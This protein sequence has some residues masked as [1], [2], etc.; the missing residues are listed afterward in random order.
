MA[1]FAAK[2]VSE[3]ARPGIWFRPLL[4]AA[5]RPD[6]LRLARNRTYLDPS[7]PDVLAIVGQDT[8]RLSEWGYGLI[9][10]DYSS[11][12]ILGRWG[13]SMGATLT[14]DGWRFAD[15]SRTTAEIVL[16]FYQALRRRGGRRDPDRLQHVQPPLGGT[17]RDQPDRR[18]HERPLVGPHATDGR[19]H[20]RLPRAR[21]TGPST[22]PI[23]TSRRSPGSTR[24]RRAACGFACSARAACRRSCRRRLRR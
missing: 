13:F 23:P 10:H 6:A 4:A 3:G 8:R 15:T 22:R 21:I 7:L 16:R 2:I 19:Q 5:T 12:D 1:A 17:V 18:R 14:D 11:F 9:K 24:G 20:A